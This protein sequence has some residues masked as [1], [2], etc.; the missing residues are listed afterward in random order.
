MADNEPPPPA[1]LSDFD[2]LAAQPA[3]A[4]AGFTC[5]RHGTEA[6]TVR[7]HGSEGA[8]WILIMESFVCRHQ[9]RIGTDK[10]GALRDALGRADVGRIYAL[11]LEWAPFFCPTC[12]KVYCGACWR[13]W[14]EFDPDF[15]GW[16]EEQRGA[17]PEGHERMLSD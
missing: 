6:G 9:E 13:T 7:L 12:A 3:V 11:D 16:L 15:P 10:A 4:Q 8:G 2:A 5:A 14:L 17:C 1:K